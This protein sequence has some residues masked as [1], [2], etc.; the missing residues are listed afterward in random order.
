MKVLDACTGSLLESQNEFVI[1]Q[2]TKL[3]QRYVAQ[4][5]TETEARS[6]LTEAKT[7]VEE[8]QKKEVQKE[9]ERQKRKKDEQPPEKTP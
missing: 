6:S 2:W 9:L 1:G 4:V 8:P 7:Q 5:K 3:P